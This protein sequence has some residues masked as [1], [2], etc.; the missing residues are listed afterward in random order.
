MGVYNFMQL[1]VVYAPLL[2][3]GV[4]NGLNREI[5]LS[6]GQGK[7]SEAHRLASVALYVCY[8]ISLIAF[9]GMVIGT[10]LAHFA[11]NIIW[12]WGLA[13]FSIVIPLTIY[14]TYLEVT[15]RTSQDFSWLSVTKIITTI[16]GLVFLPLM[17]IDPWGG[18]LVRAIL[19]A[20]LC[21]LLLWNKRPFQVAPSWDKQVFKRLFT[22][23]L[24]IFIVGY[25][26][27]LFTSMDRLIITNQLDM[28]AMGLYTPALLILQGMMILPASV[29]QVIYPRAAEQFGRDG[30]I[31]KLFPLLF[32]PLPIM[33]GIQMPFVAVGWFYMDDIIIE[34]MPKYQEGIAAARLA[35]LVGLVLSMTTPAIIF[36]VLRRQGLYAMLILA[37]ILTI[38]AVWTL[39]L[40]GR[41][42]VGVSIAVLCGGLCF[43]VTSAAGAWMLC[44]KNHKV[45]NV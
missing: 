40:G 36:N 29:A 8:I 7:K 20:L 33:L 34:F 32:L 10:F 2:T 15:F 12:F 11:G 13:A 25:I 4:Y 41:G 9:V 6:I 31:T 24:P 45:P 23:G 3:L 44:R 38:I 16:L 22:I 42:L 14:R 1:L 39:Q 43:A 28:M 19:V 18:A 21:A 5:P 26:Y 27:V 30:S 17:Y 37:S 35:L